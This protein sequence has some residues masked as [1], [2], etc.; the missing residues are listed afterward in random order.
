MTKPHFFVSYSK[1]TNQIFYCLTNQVATAR[2]LLLVQWCHIST[3]AMLLT[4]LFQQYSNV[5]THLIINNCKARIISAITER[6]TRSINLKEFGTS[7]NPDDNKTIWSLGSSP[8]QINISSNLRWSK[9][10]S[11]KTLFIFSL[12]AGLHHF[13]QIKLSQHSWANYA[14]QQKR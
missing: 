12:R 4:K 6:R 5:T 13:W 2:G 3:L 9:S 1:Q 7:Y 8:K 14:V 11:I 10:P